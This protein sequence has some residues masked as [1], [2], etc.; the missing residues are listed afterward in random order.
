MQYHDKHCQPNKLRLHSPISK[1]LHHQSKA[2][3]HHVTVLKLQ[4]NPMSFYHSKSYP[5]QNYAQKATG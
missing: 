3:T 5:C 1:T 4:Q 2:Q